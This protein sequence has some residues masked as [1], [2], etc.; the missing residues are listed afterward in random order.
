MGRTIEIFHKKIPVK[1]LVEVLVVKIILLM[2]LSSFYLLEPGITGFVS[3]SKEVNYT[4]ALDVVFSENGTYLWTLNNVGDLRNL[5]IDGSKIKDGTARVYLE[6]NGIKYLILDSDN[7]IDKG[8]GLFGITGYVV[9][10]TEEIV[11]N[12]IGTL[13]EE[14]EQIVNNLILDIN[15]SRNNISIE[16]DAKKNEGNNKTNVKEKVSGVTINQQNL[17]DS[18]A[19]LLDNTTEEVTITITSSFESSINVNNAPVWIGP[20]SFTINN[21]TT[22][23]LDSY[24]SDADNDNLIYSTSNVSNVSILI[25][26]N[27]ITLIPSM[28][29]SETKS[30]LF[31]AYDGIDITFKTVSLVIDTT[32]NNETPENQTTTNETVEKIINVDL[33]YGDNE[34]YDANDDGIETITGIVDFTS[35]DSVFNWE[36]DSNNLCTRYDVESVED[37]VI[38]SL[39]YGSSNC[40][41]FVNLQNSRDA[42]NE[43]LYLSYGSYGAS[44]NNIVSAQVL[45]I[46]YNLSADNPYSDVVYSSWKNL[47]AKFEDNT[48]R[49]TDTCVDTC[50]LSGFNDTSYTLIIEIENTTL[51]IDNLDY[52]I[53]EKQINTEPTLV[54]EIENITIKNTE[55]YTINLSKYFVDIDNDVL[56]YE[57]FTTEN[58]SIVF[59]NDTAYVASDS[60]FTGS[61]FMFITASDGF[62]SVSSNVFKIDVVKS[63][64][65][66]IEVGKPVKWS[67]K[68]NSSGGTTSIN[69]PKAA[70]NIS[71]KAISN[72]IERIVLEN[73]LMVIENGKNKSVSEHKAEKELEK[74]ERKISILEEIKDKKSKV[75]FEEGEISNIQEKSL[76]LRNEESV[77]I[78][79]LSAQEPVIESSETEV[80]VD[81]VADELVVEYYTEAPYLIE[82][83]SGINKEIRIISDTSYFNVSAYTSIK[84]VPQEA[85]KLYWVKDTG[86]ELF[87]DV[88]YVDTNSNGLIDR[89]EW[90]V[91]HL[92]NQTFEVEI[93]I[94][95]IQSYPTVGGN[96]TIRFNTTGTGNLT[97]LASNGT[98]YSELY[99]DNLSTVDDLVPLAL[100][101]GDYEYYDR[102]DL[103]NDYRFF[104]MLNNGS[105]VSLGDTIGESLN[106]SG[107]YVE[108]YSCNS[109]GYWDVQVLT[110]GVHVQQFN[111][112][113]QISYGNNFASVIND[114]NLTTSPE[115]PRKDDNVTFIVNASQPDILSI[116]FTV[117]DPTGT[118]VI[119]NM[120]GSRVGSLWNVTY[121]LS[122]YGT[123]LWNASIFYDNGYITNSSTQEIILMEISLNLSDTLISSAQTI[124]I[125]GHINL[126]NGTNVSNRNITVYINNVNVTNATTNSFGNYNVTITANDTG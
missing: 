64:K 93:T 15:S 16:L 56:T 73:N 77:L 121:N 96:W 68:V 34:F 3:V 18:L 9:L 44:F 48:I 2:L 5:K 10:D 74:I 6:K 21:E 11:T 40:C 83:E 60:S 19:A 81:E 27:M 50:V 49:F 42:W 46:D 125:S 13:T 25:N 91:P 97:I 110:E 22:I 45:H 76:E 78:S 105:K 82:E 116:N 100:T 102:N 103:V 43:S 119:D 80:V 54:K 112:S 31:A 95:N 32:I 62:G 87:N 126:S 107:V 111:F 8:S 88:S 51:T 4:D 33:A 63:V 117:I 7:L 71:V 118:K 39:C 53:I 20:E 124:I 101:C 114:S 94:L 67:K 55:N 29:I 59:E 98:T 28:N 123:W 38:T 12:V 108:D 66:A 17:I 109:T 36:V 26:D 70:S 106:V 99:G 14:Q 72:D 86:R 47:T 115:Y 75:L 85:I 24:F 23:D 79:G 90:I 41:A 37:S 113:G 35:K 58:V 92:S 69:L 61:K 30:L 120:N 1:V 89:L 52:S 104:V 122:S 57:P 65:T 84:E